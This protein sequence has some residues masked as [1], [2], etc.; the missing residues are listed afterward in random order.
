VTDPWLEFVAAASDREFVGYFERGSAPGLPG[1]WATSF[2]DPDDVWPVSAD[3]TAE[4]LDARTRGL[5]RCDKTRAI[6]GYV[7]FDATALFEPLLR[8]VP[9][10]SPFPLG[11]WA[12][13][14]HFRRRRVDASK[15]DLRPRRFH[16]STAPQSD[17]LPQR[18]FERSVAR[19]RK[20]VGDGEAFQVVLSHRRSWDRPEDLLARA[21]L[22][23]ARERFAYFYYLRFGE[24]EIVGA[25]PESVLETRGGRAYLSPIAATRPRRRG[26]R[27]KALHRDAKELAE[28]RMLVDLARNDLGRISRP[29]SVRVV[30]QERLERFARLEHLISRVQGD[31][32]PSTGPWGALAATFPAGTV[33]GAPK[34]RATELIRREERTWRGPYAG[35]VGLIRGNGE[36]AWALAI[37]SAFTRKDRL[38]TAAGAGIVWHSEPRREFRETLLKLEEVETTLVG[39]PR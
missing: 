26:E 21:T 27:R 34:I 37:R 23:R 19:L 4:E 25:S 7:G 35:A 2:T 31:L 17:T 32:V 28:H 36:A 16:R 10:G 12:L 29:G 22:L 39:S 11:E 9:R 33:S 3:E 5:L 13:V 18:R 38:Y 24:R 1:R 15:R 20:A 30:W 14:S 6:I 8:R